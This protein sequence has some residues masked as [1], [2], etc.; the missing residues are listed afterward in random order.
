MRQ[1]NPHWPRIRTIRKQSSLAT[2]DSRPI[3]AH[4]RDTCGLYFAVAEQRADRLATVSCI[5]VGGATRTGW[6]PRLNGSAPTFALPA[7]LL[8]YSCFEL[9]SPR[10]RGPTARNER[11]SGHV[12]LL[13]HYPPK[14]SVS[15]MVNSLNGVSS[16]LLRLERADIEKRY[17]KNEMD[18]DE[19]VPT[20]VLAKL[21]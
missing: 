15:S 10:L 8:A 20:S 2:C 16:R 7:L 18:C 11:R 17:W 1:P 6:R 19:K 3:R 13:I 5:P 9:A 4:T 12:Y 14:Y 21:R